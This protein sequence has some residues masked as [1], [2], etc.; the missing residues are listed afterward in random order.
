MLS[1]SSRIKWIIFTASTLTL[2]SLTAI[3]SIVNEIRDDLGLSTSLTVLIIT[4]Y[5]LIVVFMSPFVGKW[6]DRFGA[7]NLLAGGLFIYAASGLI[8]VIDGSLLTLIVSRIMIGIGVAAIFSTVTVIMGD[9]YSG[10]KLHHLMGIRVSINN[11]SA[12]IWP[13][14]GG[15]LGE[16][17]W[18]TPFAIY[19]VGFPLG[20][21][22]LK[23]LPKTHVR[24]V[25][26][27]DE[28]KKSLPMVIR[29]NPSLILIYALMFLTTITLSVGAL[30][31]P[32][33]LKHIGIADTVVI[34]FYIS[35]L[36]L[37]VATTS[38][39]YGWI[40]DHLRNYLI[41]VV[42]LSLW[43]IGFSLLTL[44]PAAMTIAIAVMVI[45]IGRGMTFPASIAWANEVG[46]DAERGIIVS[47]DTAFAYL[48]I[49]MA[50]I[51]L[52]P[53]E[54]YGGLFGVFGAL[55]LFTIF[56]LVTVIIGGLVVKYRA[57][58][59]HGDDQDY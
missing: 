14:L 23:E 2:M 21:L 27:V 29:E 12:V 26:K 42:A 6:I 43:V 58:A 55:T 39:F 15:L 51:L 37:A 28:R 24:M 47:T 30:F 35:T 31:I 3:A 18:Q 49:F 38:Y 56:V 19:M 44:I 50:P 53:A 7:K 1:K 32:Q 59:N 45:G 25:E 40:M 34:G 36:T 8:V 52:I 13:I 54:A 57:A 5:A 41:V 48:G 9:V 11:V 17:S 46:P 22:V 33:L 10:S 16:I 20:A 4:L